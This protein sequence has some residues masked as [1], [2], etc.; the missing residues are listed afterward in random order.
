MTQL[1]NSRSPAS[2]GEHSWDNQIINSGENDGS[3]SSLN[4]WIPFCRVWPKNIKHLKILLCWLPYDTS[5]VVQYMLKMI[6]F[7]IVSIYIFSWYIWHYIVATI[8]QNV[9]SYSNILS[10]FVSFLLA[11]HI[12]H[13]CS[14]KLQLPVYHG[15]PRK[16]LLAP[17]VTSPLCH[18]WLWGWWVKEKCGAQGVVGVTHRRWAFTSVWRWFY[19]GFILMMIEFWQN[20]NCICDIWTITL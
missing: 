6:I 19:F 10:V 13:L 17:V 8:L 9:I 7:M 11:S 14:L 5:A 15:Y 18:I 4:T 12:L 20:F 1:R 3:F 2:K 16:V